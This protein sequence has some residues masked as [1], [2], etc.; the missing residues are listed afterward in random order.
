MMKQKKHPESAH[1]RVRGG[2]SFIRIHP[3]TA[4][5]AL[6]LSMCYVAR[7]SLAETH[8]LSPSLSLS[9]SLSTCVH[10]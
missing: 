3:D 10:Y 9:L 7:I 5:Y 8:T 2:K 4:T 1:P 6:N